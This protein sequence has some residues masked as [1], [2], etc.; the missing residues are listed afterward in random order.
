MIPIRIAKL[1]RASRL[2]V[3]PLVET[4]AASLAHTGGHPFGAYYIVLMLDILPR[5][6]NSWVAC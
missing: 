4:F 2:S 5:L 3:E 6:F 1:P